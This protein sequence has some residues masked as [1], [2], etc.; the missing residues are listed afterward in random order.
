M[1]GLALAF[2]RHNAWWA[3]FNPDYTR[4]VFDLAN[5]AIERDPNN[6]TA[7]I[8]LA[9]AMDSDDRWNE[10]IRVANAE[11]AIDP[12]S[13]ALICGARPVK[14]WSIGTMKASQMSKRPGRMN[15]YDPDVLYWAR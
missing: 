3:N 8:A 4:K 2:G 7:Y 14:R 15:R 12:H 9:Y 5:R 1:A 13:A 10:V 6:V 11:L